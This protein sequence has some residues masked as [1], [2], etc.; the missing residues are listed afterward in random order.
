M[1]RVA[2]RAGR[3][4]AFREAA[5]YIRHPHFVWLEPLCVVILPPALRSRS[6]LVLR[7]PPDF[8][9]RTTESL[10]KARRKPIRAARKFLAW[11]ISAAGIESRTPRCRRTANG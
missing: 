1:A 8:E 3:R 10:H 7:R 2:H 9:P 6:R 4:R 5:A 11:P